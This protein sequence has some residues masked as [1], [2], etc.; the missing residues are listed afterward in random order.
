M[1][2]IRSITRAGIVIA[3]LTMALGAGQL[4]PRSAHAFQFAACRSDPVVV[5]SNLGTLDLSANIGDST[6]DVQHIVYV[7][8]APVGTR[9]LLILNTDG[10]VGLKESVQF[11][12]DDAPNTFDTYAVVYTGRHGVRVTA[13][14]LLVS[15][16]NL[17]LGAGSTGGQSG[18]YLHTHFRAGLSL[19]SW[20]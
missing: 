7:V 5:L 6:G 15:L 2:G 1:K 19:L 3:A 11:Y 4:A 13:E 9:P 12:A 10:L 18:Q 16:L 20:L 17:N 14:T 8:H